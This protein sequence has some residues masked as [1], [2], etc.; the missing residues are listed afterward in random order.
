MYHQVANEK[1]GLSLD[2]QMKEKNL[3][4]K[5]QRTEELQRQICSLKEDSKL[6]RSQ[7]EELKE[8]IRNRLPDAEN[9]LLQPIL[10]QTLPT[11]S[12]QVKVVKPLRG[13]GGI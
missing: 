3:Q 12:Q 4:R 7:C 11:Y 10:S 9:I 2:I 13:G 1:T 8:V 5:T 6:I